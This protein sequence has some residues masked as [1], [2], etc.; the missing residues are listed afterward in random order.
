MSVKN[1]LWMIKWMKKVSHPT[2]ASKNRSTV[3]KIILNKAERF[4]CFRSKTERLD[5]LTELS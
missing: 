5:E 2:M 1:A 3:I 4:F